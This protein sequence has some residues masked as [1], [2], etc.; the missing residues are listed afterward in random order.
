MSKI[1]VLYGTFIFNS[2]T[3][4]ATVQNIDSVELLDLD[5]EDIYALAEHKCE[6]TGLDYLV[7][8]FFDGTVNW[9]L[10]TQDPAI[11]QIDK[12]IETKWLEQHERLH[13]EALA[14][15]NAAPITKPNETTQND[16]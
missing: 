10:P 12:M 4:S 7:P 1:L 3:N 14:K 8:E 16:N 2:V 15:Y 6:L 9:Q 11:K 13:A 5:S